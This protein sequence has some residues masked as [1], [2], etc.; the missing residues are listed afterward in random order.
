[1]AKKRARRHHGGSVRELKSGRWQV[2]V[3]DRATGRHVALGT[4]PTKEEANAALARAVADQDRGKWVRPD[5]AHIPVGDYVQAWI[6]GHTG[7]SPRTRERYQGV[8]DHHI[9][10]HLGEANLGHLTTA[11]VRRWHTKLHRE[12]SPATAAK[13]YRLLR[14][15][16]NGAIEDGVL[17]ANPC[18]VKGAGI[19][20]SAERPIATVAEVQALADAVPD[21]WR[22]L[23]L[24]GAWCSLR[25]GELCALT[26]ADLDLLHGKVKVT[27]NL[28][29]L[30]DGTLVVVK[31]KT[32]AGRRTVTIPP[33]LLPEV[34]RHLEQYVGADKDAL[35]FT[36]S[37]GTPLRRDRWHKVWTKARR[38]VG[39]TDLA[40]HDLRHTGNTLAEGRGVAS[41][42]SFGRPRDRCAVSDRGL[43]GLAAMA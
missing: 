10:P 37:R 14:A 19:D 5:R 13:A 25:L 16:C 15:V 18:Q 26:R 24:L 30:D 22:L 21:R 33:P 8:L 1:M 11:T 39:R 43:G 3:H 32:D 42:A 36:T 40:F 28:Q 34:T 4:Y 31:P 38:E 20:R 7:L 23:V 29:R 12:A 6:D 35:V 41:D 27:K 9:A 2:R 17:A